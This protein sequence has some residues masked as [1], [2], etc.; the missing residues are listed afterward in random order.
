LYQLVLDEG[1]AQLDDRYSDPE[2]MDG[3]YRR[4]SVHWD[5]FDKNVIAVN[6]WPD[7]LKA[8]HGALG[9]LQSDTPQ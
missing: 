5:G 7:P 8:I 6:T 1:V 3:G 4:L 9:A 2:I